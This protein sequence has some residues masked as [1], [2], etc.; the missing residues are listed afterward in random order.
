MTIQEIHDLIIQ[1]DKEGMS[2]VP[3]MILKDR[4]TRAKE[5]LKMPFGRARIVDENTRIEKGIKVYVYTVH[6]SI[7]ELR[8]IVSHYKS[9]GWKPE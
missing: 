6:Y 2:I 4:K 3:L 7:D 9:Q 8:K 5:F 1:A